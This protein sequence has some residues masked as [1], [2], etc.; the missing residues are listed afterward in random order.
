MA[1]LL[2]RVYD[3]QWSMLTQLGLHLPP[4]LDSGWMNNHLIIIDA[5][6]TMSDIIL[7]NDHST[8][9][10]PIIRTF[11]NLIEQKKEDACISVAWNLLALD[12]F[13]NIIVPSPCKPQIKTVHWYVCS[14]ITN[15]SKIWKF[16]Q[17]IYY[18]SGCICFTLGDAYWDKLPKC[19]SFQKNE[20]RMRRTTLEDTN[21]SKYAIYKGC[22]MDWKHS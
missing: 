7:R 19:S 12:P 14:Y 8:S 2:L 6:C 3:S 20:C 1:V 16:Y 18:P 10:R 22:W 13:L 9:R 15:C 11:S 21:C 4:L 17:N 5:S